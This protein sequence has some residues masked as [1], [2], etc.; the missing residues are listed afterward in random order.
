[1]L[2]P[3]VV[4]H[5]QLGL[6]EWRLFVDGRPRLEYLRTLELLDRL[7]P[8]PPA[9]ILDVGGATGVYAVPLCERG[10]EVHVV[11]PIPLHVDRA[12]QIAR[13]RHLR[14]M[15]ASLG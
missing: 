5:Y 13:D 15:T 12:H 7:L 1:M 9:R 6:E 11:D 4:T 3:D 8:V 14:Q 2:D 10:Y